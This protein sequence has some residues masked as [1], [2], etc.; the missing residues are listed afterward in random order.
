M[1]S[2]MVL[3][4]PVLNPHILRRASVAVG[5]LE[6]SRQG[7]SP[8]FPLTQLFNLFTA[9]SVYSLENTPEIGVTVLDP[10]YREM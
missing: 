8:F 9:V 3:E 6:I 7:T 4:C 2:T 1:M 10:G 5:I